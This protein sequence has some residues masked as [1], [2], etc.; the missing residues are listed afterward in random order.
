MKI[1][2]RGTS[3]FIE[4]SRDELGILNNCINDAMDLIS[5][6]EFGTRVGATP[7]EAEALLD[8]IQRALRN[9]E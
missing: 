5:P 4:V 7:E 1:E 8:I 9:P 6:K 3:F 2:K